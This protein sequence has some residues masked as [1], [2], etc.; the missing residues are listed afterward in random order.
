LVSLDIVR[1]A[2]LDGLLLFGQELSFRALTIAA[3]ISV[4]QREDVV[5]VAVVNVRPRLIVARPSTSWR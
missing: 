5:E 2:L 4:L 1:A 3:E